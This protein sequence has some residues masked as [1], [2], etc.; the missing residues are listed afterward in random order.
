MILIVLSRPAGAQTPRISELSL[1]ELSNL[2]VTSVSRRPQSLAEAPASIF[3]I[4][5]EDIRRA[6]V[7]SLAEALRIAPNLQV[8]RLDSSQYAVTARGFNGLAS[9]KLLVLVDG[10]TIYTP[11]FSGV[12]W[13]QQDVFTSPAPGFGAPRLSLPA[14][15]DAA[16]FRGRRALSRGSLRKVRL[17]TLR[18]ASRADPTD[19]ATPLAT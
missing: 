3:V 19:Q 16:V 18:V 5:A 6:G 17:A 7:T 13:D 1:E 8:A 11:L 10:R 14:R 12:F 9:N 4:T 2:E 15:L